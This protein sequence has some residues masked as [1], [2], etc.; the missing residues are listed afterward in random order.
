[1]KQ[2]LPYLRI[3][4]VIVFVINMSQRFFLQDYANRAELLIGLLIFI[5]LVTYLLFHITEAVKEWKNDYLHVR[6]IRVFACLMEVLFIF[7]S[8]LILISGEAGNGYFYIYMVL[9]FLL[10]VTFLI[11]NIRRLFFTD[12][13]EV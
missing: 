13:S 7:S 4:L 5:P 12:S 1:M 2:G 9:I 6:F 10:F 11:I 8:V 3:V